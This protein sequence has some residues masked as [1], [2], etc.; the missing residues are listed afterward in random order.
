MP[1]PSYTLPLDRG[2]G[3]L[4]DQQRAIDRLQRW[5]AGGKLPHA[6]L[7]TGIAGVGKAVAATLFAMA[8]NC[9]EMT[10][11]GGKP[12]E[13][14][15]CGRCRACRKTCAGQHPDVVT[16]SPVNGMIRIDQIRSIT[17]M[18]SMR[19]YEARYRVVIITDAQHLHPSAANALLKTL[20][21]PPPQTVLIMTAVQ[22]SDL[23]PTVVS[24]CQQLPLRAIGSTEIRRILTAE[25][26]VALQWADVAAG[27]AGGSLAR[28]VQMVDPEW[29]S[30]R[31][32]LL[33][34]LAL[35]PGSPVQRLLAL[36][37]RL[38]GDQKR[39][40]QHLEVAGSW[41][42]DLLVARTAPDQII[43]MDLSE[44]IRYVAAQ[45]T[46]DSLLAQLNAVLEIEN[47]LKAN[48]NARLALEKLLLFLANP[49][50][51]PVPETPQ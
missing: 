16:V 3:A 28:A 5:L 45:M 31:D 37:E 48:L 20:E 46:V 10:V 30:H 44:K 15:P 9:S 43:N 32:W 19:P 21:E 38:A 49:Q 6:V 29:K 40:Q 8:C 25:L 12:N 2:F 23:L 34:E 36:A 42:R 47:D 51:V 35:L 18:L 1:V 17:R 33:D 50:A 27:M 24:R 7:I 4:V 13:M 41:Y 14:A 11:G 26:N 22:A 39:L